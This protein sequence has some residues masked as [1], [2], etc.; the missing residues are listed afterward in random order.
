MPAQ[1]LAESGP[2]L[3]ALYWA[4]NISLECVEA[5]TQDKGNTLL[6]C[7]GIWL[8]P[9]LTFLECVHCVEATTQDLLASSQLDSGSLFHTH[10][11]ELTV[12]PLSQGIWSKVM[13]WSMVAGRGPCAPTDCT[14]ALTFNQ[15]TFP[16]ENVKLRRTITPVACSLRTRNSQ[17]NYNAFKIFKTKPMCNFSFRRDKWTLNE[18]GRGFPQVSEIYSRKLWF[19]FSKLFADDLS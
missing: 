9:V 19:L 15:L 13:V 1:A 18:F 2:S 14:P 5:P 4:N 11:E 8:L 7:V 12:D 6:V 3:L 16:I 17:S 10:Q